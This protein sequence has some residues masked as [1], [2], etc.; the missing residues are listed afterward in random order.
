MTP[1]EALV[2]R[3]LY[4][5]GKLGMRVRTAI[6]VAEPNDDSDEAV[7]QLVAA[8]KAGDEIQIFCELVW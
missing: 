4:D 2:W 8:S 3:R 5:T 7:A 6:Y 1:A